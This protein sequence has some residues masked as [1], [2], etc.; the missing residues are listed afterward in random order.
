MSETEVWKTSCDKTERERK[1][2]MKK[3]KRI[4][5]IQIMIAS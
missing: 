3:E 1:W 5:E 2:E 4:R